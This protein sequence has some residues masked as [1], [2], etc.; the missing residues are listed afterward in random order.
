V[1]QQGDY[2]LLLEFCNGGNLEDLVKT[3]GGNL[4][5]REA[6]FILKQIINGMKDQNASEIIHRDLKLENIGLVFEGVEFKEISER[7]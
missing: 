2:Y 4:E 3:R 5:E 6:H 7:R 1:N